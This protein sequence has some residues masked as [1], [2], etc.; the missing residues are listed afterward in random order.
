MKTCRA[1]KARSR[2]GIKLFGFSGRGRNWTPPPFFSLSANEAG[3]EGRGEVANRAKFRRTELRKARKL[4]PPKNTEIAKKE[5]GPGA[6][7]W[8]LTTDEHG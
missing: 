8:L 1:I 3:G 2:E 7:R 4:Q 6:F 5:L